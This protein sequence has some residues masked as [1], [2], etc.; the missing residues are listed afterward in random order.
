MNNGSG[1]ENNVVVSPAMLPNAQNSVES[2]LGSAVVYKALDHIAGL[3]T[4]SV[5]NVQ[6][7]SIFDS[8]GSGVPTQPL[9]ESITDVRNMASRPQFPSLVGITSSTVSDGK[10]NKQ[11]EHSGSGSISSA[12][13]QV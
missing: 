9:Q 10:L 4:Q 13:S 11:D 1:H 3:A 5:P 7:Q 12:Y 6:Q 8:V 2:D